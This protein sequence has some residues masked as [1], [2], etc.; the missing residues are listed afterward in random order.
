M[1]GQGDDPAGRIEA[2]CQEQEERV[3]SLL[4]ELVEIN[5]FSA[6][7]EGLI[8]AGELIQT[9]AREMGLELERVY[10]QGDRSKPFNLLLDPSEAEGFGPGFVGLIGHFD[11]VHPPQGGFTRL[12]QKGGRLHGPGTQDMKSGLVSALFAVQVLT[13]LYGRPPRVKLVLNCDEEIGS[14]GSRDLIET[15]MAGARAVLVLEGRLEGNDRVITARKGIAG[16]WVE[17]LG[18]A[19]HASLGAGKGASAVLEMA[20]KIVRLEELND[21]DNEITVSTGLIQGG[22]TMNT[23]PALCRAEVDI[24]FA[25]TRGE[26]QVL[27]SVRKILEDNT[28]PGTRTEYKLLTGRPAMTASPESLRLA[29]L[30]QDCAAVYGPVP[31]A[32]PAGGGSDANFTAALGIPTLDGLGPVGGGPHTEEEYLLQGSLMGNLKALCLFIHRLPGD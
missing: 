2:L 5:S 25:T 18:Q 22:T 6:N 28:V 29:R 10:P 8:R 19:A 1:T 11:T 23:I 9:R 24:R 21:P 31:E 27:A 30:F 4:K 7:P 3:F 12:S 26:E 16:A 20:R 13:G 17:V 32:G 15:Q 14:T